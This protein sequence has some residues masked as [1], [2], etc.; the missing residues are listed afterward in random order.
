M[1]LPYMLEYY[2]IVEHHKQGKQEK[3]KQTIISN[4]FRGRNKLKINIGKK[5]CV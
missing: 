5:T 4:K 1:L 3:Q 2:Y